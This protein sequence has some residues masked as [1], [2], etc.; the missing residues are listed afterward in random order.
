MADKDVEKTEEIFD[1]LMDAEEA[2]LHQ[3]G[4]GKDKIEAWK[5]EFGYLEWMAFDDEVF[6][7]RSINRSE[8]RRIFTQSPPTALAEMESFV[9]E[10]I[11][12][13]AL[14]FPAYDTIDWEKRAGLQR[15]LSDNIMRLSGF[16]PTVGPRR[17]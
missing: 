1:P 16:Q 6:V 7:Y 8:Y 11:I 4:P 13:A 12:K 17:I 15:T 3:R 14:L 2:F 10:E 9:E 5:K